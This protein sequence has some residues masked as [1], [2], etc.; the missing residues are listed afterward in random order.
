VA[1]ERVI[2][3]FALGVEDRREMRRAYGRSSRIFMVLLTNLKVVLETLCVSIQML[4]GT[5]G[6]GSSWMSFCKC[7]EACKVRET[8]AIGEE[9]SVTPSPPVE[10]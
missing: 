3:A 5:A 7:V 2:R 8:L 10:K 9:M 6:E 4:L 1:L